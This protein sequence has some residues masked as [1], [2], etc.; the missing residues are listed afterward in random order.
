MR[1]AIHQP[2]FFP[3]LGYFHRVSRVERWVFFDHVQVPRG[4][5]WVS[6]NR[7]L[8]AGTPAWLTIP[9]EKGGEDFQTRKHQFSDKA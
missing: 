8:L 6:R 3:W 7:I 1:I 9:I 2:N 4:K 5:S